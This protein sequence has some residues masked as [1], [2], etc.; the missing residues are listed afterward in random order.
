[1]ATL[2][3]PAS[4]PSASAAPQRPRQRLD[5]TDEEIQAMMAPYY[6]CMTEHG[7][8]IDKR[9]LGGE[10]KPVKID[11]NKVDAAN[12]I[13]EP[14]FYP[15]PAWE[16]DPANPEARDFALGVVKCL[17][18]KGVEYVATG[19]DGLG[20]E[21]GGDQ[22]DERSITLGLKYA[23]GCERKVAAELK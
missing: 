3:S 2:A 23:A 17:K 8:E 22:N 16:R 14:Q 4:S 19:D 6:R 18:D 9:K 15:L 1:M 5:S 21:F 20:L 10:G 13:C 11:Q 12:K 7:A